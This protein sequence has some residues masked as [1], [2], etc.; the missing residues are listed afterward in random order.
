MKISIGADHAGFELKNEVVTYL[1]SLGHEV[2]DLGTNSLDS[3]D[4]PLFASKV[5]KSVSSKKTDLGVLICG[6]GVGM[7][8][9]ANKHMGIRAVVTSE[10]YSAKASREHN[11]ANVLCFGARVVG[12]ELAKMIVDEFL[13]AKYLG[14]RHQR[15]VDL[16][17]VLDD[18]GEL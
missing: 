3:T 8:I 5:A 4:Y 18:L 14:D 17:E 16:L 15:R 9:A 13:N 12:L 10:P 2:L 7:S 11:N 6:T 1:K